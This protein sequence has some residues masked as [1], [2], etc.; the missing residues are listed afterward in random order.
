MQ[1]CNWLGKR[2]FEQNFNYNTITIISFNLLADWGLQDESHILW[3]LP[4]SSTREVSYMHVR[5]VSI[6]LFS[7]FIE[8]SWNSEITFVSIRSPA[9]YGQFTRAAR[10]L[11][12]NCNPGGC[13]Q[14]GRCGQILCPKNPSTLY[15]KSI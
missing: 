8:L 3:S 11:E 13:A 12:T 10:H 15:S 7:N 5:L 9:A 1:P 2:S 6:L 4:G 14:R